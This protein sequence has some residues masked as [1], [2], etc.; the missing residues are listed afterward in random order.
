LGKLYASRR[1][2]A[3]SESYYKDALARREKAAGGKPSMEVAT[4]LNNLGSL[5]ED[6]G[7]LVGA[8]DYYRQA[9]AIRRQI[10]PSTHPAIGVSLN[11]LGYVLKEQGDFSGAEKCYREALLIVMENH[12]V[13][14]ARRGGF[15]RNLAAVELAEGKIAEAVANAREAASIFHA[16]PAQPWRTADADSLLGACLVAQ[17]K[18]QEAEPLLLKSY[19]LLKADSG[20][21]AKRADEARQRIVD[22]YTSWGKPEKAAEFRAKA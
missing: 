15:L 10:L 14:E 5:Q 4:S 1:Q 20:E 21:G 18:F 19:P 22:L 16:Y 7:N 3:T 13:N 12:P 9:L 11:N 6:R 2:Y 17:G 8:A